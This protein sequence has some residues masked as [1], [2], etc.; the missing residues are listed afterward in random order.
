MPSVLKTAFIFDRFMT[1]VW[2]CCPSQIWIEPL[3]HIPSVSCCF[4]GLHSEPQN[5][6]FTDLLQAVKMALTQNAKHS[7]QWRPLN[8]QDILMGRSQVYQ[9]KGELPKS[10]Q[11]DPHLSAS[12]ICI[13]SWNKSSRFIFFSFWSFSMKSILLKSPLL[14]SC[15][16]ILSEG[17]Y[18][19]LSNNWAV[20]LSVKLRLLLSSHTRSFFTYL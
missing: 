3:S 8:R 13:L 6:S 16:V 15:D 19:R 20:I 14:P 10:R 1:F 7:H 17:L 18:F 2:F 12:W 9:E 5:L 4:S 11:Q